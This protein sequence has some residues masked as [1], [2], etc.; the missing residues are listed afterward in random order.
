VVLGLTVSLFFMSVEAGTTQEASIEAKE[1]GGIAALGINGGMFFAQLLNFIV[2]LLIFWK[3]V[4]RPIV[5]M[6]DRR[7][8]TIE[9]SLKQAKEID[10]RLLK[11]DTERTTVLAQAQQE[12]VELLSRTHAEAE[13]QHQAT[14]AKAKEEVRRLITEGKAQLIKEKEFMIKETRDEIAAL[15]IEVAKKVVQENIDKTRS[16]VLAKETIETMLD[17]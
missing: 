5:T 13:S 10:E 12:A 6:L 1:T 4:Y 7:T 11:L 15:A 8:E 9:K 2:V 3:W 16:Q 17:V 14:M